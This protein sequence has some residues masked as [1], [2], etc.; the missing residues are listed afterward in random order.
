[1]ALSAD[2]A[3]T[4]QV[5]TGLPLPILTPALQLISEVDS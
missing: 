1:M 5:V 4:A 3:V 2:K